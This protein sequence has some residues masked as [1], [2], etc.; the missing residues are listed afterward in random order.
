MSGEAFNRLFEPAGADQGRQR[1]NEPRKRKRPERVPLTETLELPRRY[2]PVVH[3]FAVSK[4]IKLATDQ[5]ER[6]NNPPLRIL[7]TEAAALQLRAVIAE[8]EE[9]EHETA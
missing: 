5:L 4:K 9:A 8:L 1:L 7:T 2:W 6:G 3:A